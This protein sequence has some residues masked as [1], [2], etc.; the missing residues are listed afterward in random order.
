MYVNLILGI[1]VI[2]ALIWLLVRYNRKDE[3]PRE[4]LADELARRRAAQE[5]ARKANTALTLL[6]DEQLRQVADDLAEMRKSLPVEGLP[7]DAFVWRMQDGKLMLVF[8]P[9][10]QT[11]K[12]AEEF[13]IG[14][15]IRNLDIN[16]LAEL[17]QVQNVPGGFNLTAPDG[18]VRY[19]AEHASLMRAL[20]GLI[21]DR[22]A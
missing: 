20:S 21:A 14:W 12:T 2:T 17:E 16:F 18:N 4:M 19:F 5:T 11:D 22:L 9:D 8:L 3:S 6:R 10:A 7:E 15:D 1:L 13:V